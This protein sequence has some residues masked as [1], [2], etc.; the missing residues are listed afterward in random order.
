MLKRTW[1]KRTGIEL[2]LTAIAL[3]VLAGC[4]GTNPSPALENAR[5]AVDQAQRN[6]DVIE[7]APTELERAREALAAAE[8]TFAEQGNNEPEL[9]AHQ[10]YLAQRLA[11]LAE[12]QGRT[13]GLNQQIETAEAERSQVLLSARTREAAAADRRAAIESQRAELARQQASDAESRAGTAESRA[14]LAAGAAV[15]NA[16]EA[17]Q[18]RRQVEE[19]QM[20]ETERGLVLTLDDVLFDVD[21]ADL[22]PGA[23]SMLDRLAGFLEEY[24]EREVLIEGHTDSTGP[25][26]YNETLSERRANAVREALTERG[27]A[28]TRIRTRGL[29][30]AEPIASNS[31]AAGRQQN[32]RVDVVIS[33]EEGAI[34][35]ADR[36]AAVRR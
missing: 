14:R 17:A 3:P 6:P 22:K 32:R 23:D 28:A 11:E 5:A 4:A 27:I 25:E 36:S 1:L 2:P 16:Q 13:A 7:S 24:E 8:S 9:L 12:T 35:L 26:N 21:A 19:L 31:T 18:L 29:G 30:E 34:P 10:V 33:D 20:Q 15:A